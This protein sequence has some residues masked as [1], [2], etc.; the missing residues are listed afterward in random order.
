MAAV[1]D[2]LD[3]AHAGG[4]VHR[5]VKPENILIDRTGKV[6]VADFGITLAMDAD[7]TMPGGVISGTLRYI[8]PEQAEGEE[9]TPRRTSGRPARCSPSW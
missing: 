6:K 4:L 3:A 5:D 7:R 8:S 9:A 1:C 2:A